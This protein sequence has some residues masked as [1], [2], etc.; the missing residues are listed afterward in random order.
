MFKTIIN[1]WKVAELKS[2]ILFTALILIIYRFGNAIPIPFINKAALQQ[3]FTSRGE[4]AFYGYLNLLTGGSFTAATI[5]ALSITPYITASIIIQLLTMAIPALE[6]M[7][8]E[9]GE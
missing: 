4:N 5:F 6:R 2:K 8:K 3:M 9:G 1:A 7:V